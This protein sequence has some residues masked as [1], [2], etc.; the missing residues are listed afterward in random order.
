MDQNNLTEVQP[1]LY[2]RLLKKEW[3]YYAGAVMISFIA[4]TLLVLT[5][6][7]W[8]ASGPLATWGAKFFSLFFGTDANGAFL[9]TKVASYKFF[10]DKV[11]VLDISIAFGALISCLL[12]ARSCCNSS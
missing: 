3:S 10:G 7:T 1:T 9:G 4:M 8:G 6:G 11:S 2:E 12:A 5:G